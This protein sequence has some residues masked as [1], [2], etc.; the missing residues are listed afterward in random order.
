MARSDW[1]AVALTTDSSKL[2]GTGLATAED[3]IALMCAFVDIKATD[4]DTDWQEE[5]AELI[6][7]AACRSVSSRR[8]PAYLERQL[9]LR[10]GPGWTA[11]V[12]DDLSK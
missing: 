9:R 10:F 4:F 11:M 5:L 3:V 7:E 1:S 6:Y 8:T 12:S 2:I